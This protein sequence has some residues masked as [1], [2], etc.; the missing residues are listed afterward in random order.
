[1]GGGSC[2]APR[3][4]RSF[5]TSRGCTILTNVTVALGL[6]LTGG[7]KAQT[8][9]TI[10]SFSAASGQNPDGYATNSDGVN[11]QAGL[12]SLLIIDSG[13]DSPQ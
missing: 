4:R 5:S 8:L 6:M 3:W 1:L 13:P 7:V 9:T 12:L 2:Q 11:P 10:Y